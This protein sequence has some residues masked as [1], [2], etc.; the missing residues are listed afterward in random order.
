MNPHFIFN[1]LNSIQDLVLKQDTD[2]TYDSIVLFAELIRNALSYSNQ[3]F[4]SIN[5]ELQF[6]NVYLQLEKLRFGKEFNYRISYN[7][8]N[9]LE[10]PSLLI[11]PFIENALVHGLLHKPGKKELNIKFSFTQNKL[12]CIITDNGIGRVKAKEIGERQGNHHESFALGAI[13]KRLEIFKKQYNQNIGYSI[14]DLYLDGAASG[15]KVVVIM[16]FKNRF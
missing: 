4:I 5:K 2:A 15:T 7:E 12:Q 9:D 1:A 3:D 11:Q 14:E 6:L 8:N 10:V 16:P 13:E